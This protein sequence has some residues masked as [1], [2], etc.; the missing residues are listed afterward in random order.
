MRQESEHSDRRRNQDNDFGLAGLS[1]EPDCEQSKSCCS[2]HREPYNTRF[3]FVEEMKHAPSSLKINLA[4][5]SLAGLW[6]RHT[7]RAYQILVLVEPVKVRALAGIQWHKSQR[8]TLRS[9]GYA[10]IEFHVQC[11][12]GIKPWLK[13]HAPCI[14]II[15]EVSP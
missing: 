8:C 13:H 1:A 6:R 15:R 10:M 11:L 3:P 4:S 7:P 9:D 14:Q 12:G 2:S 5:N